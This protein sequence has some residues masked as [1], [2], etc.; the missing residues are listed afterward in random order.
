MRPA[1]MVMVSLV[2]LLNLG[3]TGACAVLPDFT[4][5]GGSFLLS[6]IQSKV[7]GQVTAKEI[8]GN[9]VSG[10]VF[11]DLAITAPD[12]KVFLTIDRLEARLSLASIPT[13]RL[14]LGTLALDNPRVYLDRDTSGQWNFNGLLKPEA[15]PAKPAE[16]QGL[17]GK[18]TPYLFQGIDLSNILVHRGE[19]FITEGGRTS[20][21]SDLDLKANLTFLNWGQPQQKIKIDISSLGITTSQGRVELEARLTSIS[22]TTRIDSLNLKLA[23]QTVAS[24]KGEVCSPLTE[25]S[26]T[27]TG[28]IG[29]I[30]GDLIHAL[31]PRWPAPWDL[32]GT[33]SLS[34]TPAG[35]K[36]Q[37][38]GKI[39]EATCDLTGDLDTKVKPAVFKLDLDLKGL[40]TAQLQALQGLK[41]Q[42]IQGL[43]PVNAH[44]SPRG[45]GPALGPRVRQDPPGPFALPVSRPQSG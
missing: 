32:A 16:P 7:N 29:L 9:P 30:K 25:L 23:G 28:K 22:G 44:L 14:D 8:S 2:L 10:V 20:H 45:H 12:G 5:W 13:F 40:T 37:V 21:Y 42:Q 3:G 36:I 38:K 39:G 31:W 35:G 17:L 1:L 15:K 27:L 24:L 18:I 43:S 26:C 19:L 6:L 11:K 41:A 4:N 34:S 33:L